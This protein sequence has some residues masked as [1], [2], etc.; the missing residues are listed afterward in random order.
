[1]DELSSKIKD[2]EFRK[3]VE[4]NN[5]R[6]TVGVSDEGN[7][8]Y[9]TKQRM[10]LSFNQGVMDLLKSHLSVDSIFALIKPSQLKNFKQELSG[11]V[12]KASIAHEI[13]HWMD[14]TFHN[15]HLSS[16]AGTPYMSGNAKYDRVMKGKENVGFT[17]YEINAQVHAIKQLIRRIPEEEWDNINHIEDI[18]DLYP[19]LNSIRTKSK[20]MS[21]IQYQQWLQDLLKRLSREG[22][23][24]KRMR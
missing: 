7:I 3:A 10:N 13:S 22:L 21:A 18:F 14:D 16:M 1:M 8:Y 5:I 17:F 12:T 24:G 19:T 6:V 2:E 20:T 9:P 23:L 4:L 15:Y 11:E